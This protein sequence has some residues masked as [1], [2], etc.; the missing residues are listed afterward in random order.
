MAKSQKD[1]QTQKMDLI[2]FAHELSLKKNSKLREFLKWKKISN[3]HSKAIV[4]LKR[5]IATITWH[6]ITNSQL[7]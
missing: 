6:L 1:S 5:K 7:C 4:A 2:Q 3:G